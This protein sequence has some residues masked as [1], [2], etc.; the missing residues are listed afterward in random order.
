MTYSDNLKRRALFFCSQGMSPGV[1]AIR[2][3]DEGLKASHQGLAKFLKHYDATGSTTRHPGSS[4]PS[5][6]TPE[7]L[8]ILE[9]QMQQDDETTAV[10]LH[11]ILTVWQYQISITTILRSRNKPGWTFRGSTYCQLIRL[12]KFLNTN[13]KT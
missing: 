13:I 4:R 10:Q 8:K 3:G 12:I 1:V 11:A 5:K 2:L 7:V 6:L 9:E